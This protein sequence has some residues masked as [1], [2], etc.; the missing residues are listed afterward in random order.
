MSWLSGTSVIVIYIASFI[1]RVVRW[2]SLLTKC[3]T[4]S[5][6]SFE[7]STVDQEHWWGLEW[8]SCEEQGRKLE[9]RKNFSSLH[10][11]SPLF[12]TIN[13]HYPT[14]FARRTRLW[15]KTDDCSH[16]TRFRHFLLLIL[17]IYLTVNEW[18]WVSYEELWRSRTAEADNT[19]RDLHN[20]SYDTNA[21]FNNCF[22][23]QSK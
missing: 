21:E 23:I 19:L 7:S 11:Q 18:G 16:S 8:W 17:I 22:I 20:S 13:S 10:P 6:F 12:C 1:H 5:Y 14:F 15:G 2:I 4:V 3:P 9:Q